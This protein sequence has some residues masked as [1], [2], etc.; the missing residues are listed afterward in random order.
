M[1]KKKFNNT[2]LQVIFYLGRKTVVY[3][4]KQFIEYISTYNHYRQ[5]LTKRDFTSS[6]LLTP[7]SSS[8]SP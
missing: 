4:F 5:I 6:K 3:F 8:C 1:F 2:K 7:S